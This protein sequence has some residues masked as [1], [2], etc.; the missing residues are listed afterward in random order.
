M[1]ATA[2]LTRR[3]RRLFESQRLIEVL[4]HAGMC[5]IRVTVNC[6]HRGCVV[7]DDELQ[8]RCHNT[9][10]CISAKWICDGVDDCGDMSDESNCSELYK[11]ELLYNTK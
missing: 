9:G 6:F 4:R 7:C 5:R 8:F 10:L 3:P 2:T 1:A 11:F